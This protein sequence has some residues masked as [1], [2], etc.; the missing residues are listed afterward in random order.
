M[1]DTSDSRCIVEWRAPDPIDS[2][3]SFFVDEICNLQALLPDTSH[4]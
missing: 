3:V 4:W 2:L 1:N